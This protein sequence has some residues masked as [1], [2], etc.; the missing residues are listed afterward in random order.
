MRLEKIDDYKS[1]DLATS[2]L[3]LLIEYNFVLKCW[4]VLWNIVRFIAGRI[5]CAYIHGNISLEIKIDTMTGC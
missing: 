1:L 3:N 5:L 4:I 2:F